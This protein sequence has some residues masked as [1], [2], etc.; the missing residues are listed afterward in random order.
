MDGAT[1]AIL[2]G[3]GIALAFV[4]LW[5]WVRWQMTAP[6][7]V[8]GPDGGQWGR[9]KDGAFVTPWRRRVK[10]PVTIAALEKAWKNE[11]AERRRRKRDL[12]REGKTEYNP[13]PN[14]FPDI[15]L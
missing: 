15:N 7:S 6:E 3:G 2:A 12:E 10:D 9:R 4:L 5:A 1:I 13:V 11:E 14:I 8:T